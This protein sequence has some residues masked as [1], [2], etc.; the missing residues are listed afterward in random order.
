MSL[1]VLSL[2][3]NRMKNN[4]DWLPFYLFKTRC[5]NDL[6][7]SKNYIFNFSLVNIN[8]N[9]QTCYSGMTHAALINV[10]LYSI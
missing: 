6:K 3:C 9:K 10:V 5:S 2:K 4:M 8:V 7:I 1:A